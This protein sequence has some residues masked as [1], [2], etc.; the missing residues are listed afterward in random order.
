MSCLRVRVCLGV[1]GVQPMVGGDDLDSRIR[2]G[3]RIADHDI[4]CV[5]D[6]E[7]L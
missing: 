2:N 5:T 1:Y 6:Y 7:T 3:R 4:F